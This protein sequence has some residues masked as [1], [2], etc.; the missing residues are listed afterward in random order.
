M[1]KKSW[2]VGLVVGIAFGLSGRAFSL[3]PSLEEAKWES[4][5][6]FNE[7]AGGFGKAEPPAVWAAGQSGVEAPVKASSAVPTAKEKRP[8]IPAARPQQDP[9]GNG[10]SWGAALLSNL[11]LAA[12]MV[13]MSASWVLFP[14]VFPATALAGAVG[15]GVAAYNHGD[16][17]WGL[18]KETYIG[19]VAGIGAL[20]LAGFAVGYMTGRFLEKVFRRP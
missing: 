5:L 9:S 20:P 8:E 14:V 12:G 16:R 19:A 1:N 4:G 13:G 6:R 15:A 7:T 2:V 3:E 18:V 17:G 11:G 10:V